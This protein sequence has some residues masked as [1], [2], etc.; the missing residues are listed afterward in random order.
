MDN[1]GVR[2]HALD[3][4]RMEA[5]LPPVLVIP[6]MG[7]FAEE[8]AWLLE[9]LGPRRVVVLD[10]RGR[11]KSDVPATGY[12]W[13]HHV[14]DVEAAVRELRLDR[15]ITVAFSRGTSY[16]L[17]YA[18]EHPD[19][20]RALVVGDYYA[21]HVGFPAEF[22]DRQL[23]SKVRGTLIAARM[24]E[25]AVRQVFAEGREVPLW[26]RLVELRCPVM[27]IR[28]GRAS[29]VVGEE[30][31]ATWLAALPSLRVEMI[32]GAGHDLW[33]REPDAYLAVLV[34]FLADIDP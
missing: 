26:D 23:Q 16:A 20:I 13:E 4:G 9:A 33:S 32:E 19:D 3:N 15:P 6:G 17:G 7:E 8:Y 18:L 2:L 1:A 27:L 28:G 21:R 11:G 12:T 5:G 30:V 24:S 14:S 34:P 22:A 29:A 25:H 31:A 10:V